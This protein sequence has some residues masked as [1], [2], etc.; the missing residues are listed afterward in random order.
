LF[1]FA[2]S[3]DNDEY[4]TPFVT[5]FIVGICL[6][7]FCY[8]RTLSKADLQI[9]LNT[10]GFS[11]HDYVMGKHGID[12]FI[13]ALKATFG[14]WGGFKWVSVVTSSFIHTNIVSLV[15]NLWLLL[16][17]GK[18]VEYAMGPVRYFSFYILAGMLANFVQAFMGPD[19]T[20]LDFGF[21]GLDW[22]SGL[23][24]LILG[25]GA[26]GAVNAVIA[27][28]VMYFPNAIINFKII[29]NQMDAAIWNYRDELSVRSS[30]CLPIAFLAYPLFVALAYC[31]AVNLFP[32]Y[33]SPWPQVGGFLWGMLLA[34]L[35]KDPEVLLEADARKKFPTPDSDPPIE[36]P[37]GEHPPR[38]TL[39]EM[40]KKGVE[41]AEKIKKERGW[42]D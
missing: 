14:F 16:L 22:Q 19:I 21:S 30:R 38:P 33:F 42:V 1:V 13:G 20:L 32:V 3:D 9:F 8:E 36:T 28:Y 15:W 31:T 5:F 7:V 2:T 39:A 27:A 6:L 4:S 12:R 29:Q 37:Y 23:I 40:R 34:M 25:S 10:Y 18:N 24:S 35:L 26:S 11:A 17:F 41:E